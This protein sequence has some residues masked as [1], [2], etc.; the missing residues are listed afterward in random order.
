MILVFFACHSRH[1]FWYTYNCD[2]VTYN[3]LIVDNSNLTLGLNL[4]VNGTI[5]L[6][7]ASNITNDDFGLTLIDASVDQNGTFLFQLLD[8]QG[9]Q[10]Y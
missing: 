4:T 2:Q 3:N 1:R 10:S 5:T 8:A 9:R 6:E 7:N